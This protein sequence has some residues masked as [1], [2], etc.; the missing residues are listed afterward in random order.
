MVI[1]SQSNST[2][3]AIRIERTVEGDIRP[4]APGF[5]RS[6]LGPATYD[7]PSVPSQEEPRVY[8][9]IQ[10]ETKAI[11]SGSWTV[12]QA[13][14][15]RSPIYEVSSDWKKFDDTTPTRSA[16]DADTGRLAV[17]VH[18]FREGDREQIGSVKFFDYNWKIEFTTNGR[19][20]KVE[21]P[22]NRLSFGNYTMW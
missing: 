14:A 19:H 5:L 6:P 2:G 10:E 8:F 20:A 15:V 11:T 1:L 4:E 13:N 22:N 9:V 16:L 7:T 17:L 18:G 21:V 12:I 3:G